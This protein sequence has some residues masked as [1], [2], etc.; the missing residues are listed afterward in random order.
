M[1]IYAHRDAYG[2]RLDV[3]IKEIARTSQLVSMITGVPVPPFKAIV[4]SNAYSHASGIHQDGVLKDRSTYEIIQP[5]DV[6]FPSNRI[7]LTS[8]SGRHA[9][10]AK[11]AEMGYN[12]SPEELNAV[13]QKFLEIADAKSHV[14]EEDLIA[15]VQGKAA[16]VAKEERVKLKSL[17]AN[18]GGA[19]SASAVAVLE[20]DGVTYE[21]AATGSGPVDAAFR[22]IR[23]LCGVDVELVDYS[24][25][26]V[27]SGADALG[28]AVARVAPAGKPGNETVGR[29]I[30]RD[31]IKASALAFV[32]AVNKLAASGGI[33][34]KPSAVGAVSSDRLA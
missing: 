22:V 32:D 10:K 5:E 17:Q 19:V 11:L 14:E 34:L 24:L 6:G 29:G 30:D 25:R 26:A 3:N 31:V 9:L 8:R 20:I 28:E 13:Y 23:R 15:I 18:S 33:E 21:D 12:L 7:I 2:V 16:R 4:G 1:A 27:T